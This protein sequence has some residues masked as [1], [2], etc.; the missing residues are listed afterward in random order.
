MQNNHYP[1]IRELREEFH[2]TQKDLAEQMLMK[3]QQYARYEQGYNDIPSYVFIHLAQT[4][5]V[6]VDYL[7]GLTDERT[8]YPRT[9]TDE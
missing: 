3:R 9:K 4:F 8:P 7:L 2:I 6:S 1:R 5:N